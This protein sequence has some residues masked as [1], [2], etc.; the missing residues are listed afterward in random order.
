MPGELVNQFTEHFGQINPWNVVW[1]V[2]NV[3]IPICSSEIYPSSR[4]EHTEFYNDWLVKTGTLE[5]VGMRLAASDFEMINVCVILPRTGLKKSENLMMQIY[6]NISG[7]LVRAIEMNRL[8]SDHIGKSV[9][10]AA[11]LAR[12]HDAAFVVDQGLKIVDANEAA[13]ASFR[14]NGIL[15]AK[16]DMVRLGD[17]NADKWL[18]AAVRS[19]LLGRGLAQNKI[20]ARHKGKL[21][22]I[23]VSLVPERDAGSSSYF[24]RRKLLALV[25]V[26]ELSSRGSFPDQNILAQSFRLS[27]AEIR[28]CCAL[29]EGYT[30]HE[31]AE[32]LSITRETV[33][34]RIKQ[35][36][37][38]TGTNRQSELIALL[39][40]F[41]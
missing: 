13:L 26:R 18:K 1:T 19:L 11:L 39:L 20:A 23:S 5:S 40:R 41:S 10:A 35:I 30:L 17:E 21:F 8:L 16:F 31:A 29:I 24:I 2:A 9:A 36:F 6:S 33:R 32:R 28:L 37:Q 34:H 15:S 4:F 22:Q 25:I 12:N 3:G 38:K 7:P 27:P 14:H